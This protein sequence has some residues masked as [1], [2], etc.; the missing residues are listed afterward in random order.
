MPY[1]D[2]THSRKELFRGY[3]GSQL[4][5][6][7]VSLPQHAGR[8]HFRLE[9]RSSD[10]SRAFIRIRKTVSTVKDIKKIA[11]QY[12][13]SGIFF[14][15]VEWLDPIHM[16]LSREQVRD[17]MLTS[18]LFFDIDVREKIL[19][20]LKAKEITTQLIDFMKHTYQKE[21]DELVFS[22]KSGFHV[23]YWNWDDIPL[24]YQHPMLDPFA[25]PNWWQ[26]G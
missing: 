8:H 15:P 17:C 1:Q 7:M 14:T 20:V 18:P 9:L 13:P 19:D 23:Y 6:S 3:Y 25:L 21:P 16:R 10:D 11:V 24:S 12:A 5:E 22:G 26:I 2:L 4:F